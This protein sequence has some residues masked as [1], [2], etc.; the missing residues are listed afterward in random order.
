MEIW[1]FNHY[2]IGPN[3]GGG[4]RHY[5]LSKYLVKKGHK[6]KIFASSFDHQTRKEK[7][8][9]NKELYKSEIHDGVEFIWIKTHPYKGNDY[10][11]V[12]NMLSYFKNAKKV[13]KLVNGNPDLVIGSLV[14]PLAAYLGYIVSKKKK[15][16]FYFEERD[17]W[18]QSLIDLGKVTEKNPVIFLL[19]KLEKYL[20]KK[21]D[22]IIVLFENAKNYVVSK[23]INEEKVLYIPNGIDMNRLETS[24]SSLPYELENYFNENNGNNIIVYTGTHGL[25]NNLDVVL[26]A[27]KE[28][29]TNTQ[30][31]FI[32]DGPNKEKLI[33]RKLNE[34][35]ENVYFAD[36]VNKDLI[37]TIL[38]K[39]SVG[40]LPLKHSPVFKWGISPNKLFDYMSNKLPVILLCDIEDSPLQQAD[41]GFVFKKDFK[42]E[43]VDLL[44]NI[45]KYDLESLGDNGYNFVKENHNWEKNSQIII[46]S[47]I[48]DKKK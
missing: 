47:A 9:F 17:L 15:S 3:S 29:K 35:I 45:N 42:N 7:H 38:Q 41:G 6:V 48:Q 16:L 1:I 30:F 24:N 31:L 5:D 25:A 43:L 19:Y 2:A 11:R 40:L 28:I 18:P 44:N 14:H 12:L 20:Y 10:N 36:P 32:G 21:A 37:P 22:R 8:L 26:D 33:Q 23:G 27:A 39:S 4:T 13:S 46:N 34:K